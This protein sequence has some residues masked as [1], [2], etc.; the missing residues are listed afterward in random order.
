MDNLLATDIQERAKKLH[1]EENACRAVYLAET[2][3][4]RDSG[5]L[6]T[7]RMLFGADTRNFVVSLDEHT[8]VIVKE[9]KG[10]ISDSSL[11]QTAHMLVDTLNAE[12]MTSVRVAYGN[13]AKA[14]KSVSQ[15]FKEARMAL[16]V[17]KIFYTD[18]TVVS[19]G[20]LGLGR[21]IYQLPVPLCELFMK[22]T[23]K[24][25]IFQELD[26][27]TLM[28]IR[29]FFENDLNIS[30]TARQMYVHRNTLVY[31]LEKLEKT[32]GLDIRK[33]EEAL[34]FKIAM[35]VESYLKYTRENP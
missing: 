7:A 2:K 25:N 16:E 5:A 24:E 14:L 20:R 9:L 28:T 32:I 21:L 10:A 27:E 34:T 33:F 22:E 29:R 12:A 4:H 6:E 8:I 26:D 11:E 3:G 30:E 1:I 15:S 19:Y 18:R 31:R 23:F 17:G 13:P 35:M